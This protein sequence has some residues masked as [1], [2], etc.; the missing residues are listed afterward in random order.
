MSKTTIPTG[1]I[2][3]NAVT[4]A[5]A[6]G[7]MGQLKNQVLTTAVTI[8][9]DS[10]TGTATGLTLAIT[11]TATNSKIL[12]IPNIAYKIDTDGRGFGIYIFRTI[13]GSATEIFD[14]NYQWL[15][16]GAA[17]GGSAERNRATWHHLDSPNT[18]SALTYS[19]NAL[20]ESG[21]AIY[22]Q[23]NTTESMLTLME[24]LV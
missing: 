23:P 14:T 22:L 4:A 11:P 2:A 15:G 21:N 16:I 20:S 19:V 10:G 5:K 12:I 8:E 18:T 3:D 1:G 6:T 13:G 9:T 17:E 24:V 7:F